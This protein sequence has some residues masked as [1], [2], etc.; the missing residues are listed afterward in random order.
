LKLLK[1]IACRSKKW[2]TLLGVPPSYR[3]I[4]RGKRFMI[5]GGLTFSLK[6]SF[7]K[8]ELSSLFI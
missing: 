1:E 4:V 5:E 6:K 2:G 8:P 3:G 7:L